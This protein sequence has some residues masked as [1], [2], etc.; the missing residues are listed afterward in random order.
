MEKFFIVTYL[1]FFLKI[2]S[3]KSKAFQNEALKKDQSRLTL[4]SRF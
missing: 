1:E 3:K 2:K 4:K